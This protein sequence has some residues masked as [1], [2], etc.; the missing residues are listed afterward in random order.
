M[1]YCTYITINI[2]YGTM[3]NTLSTGKPIRES[4]RWGIPVGFGLQL[5]EGTYV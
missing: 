5:F 4:N 3:Y 2:K 1:K